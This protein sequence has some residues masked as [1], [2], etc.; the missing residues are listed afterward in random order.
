MATPTPVHDGE[1]PGGQPPAAAALRLSGGRMLLLAVSGVLFVVALI[2][3][4]AAAWGIFSGVRE[5]HLLSIYSDIVLPPYLV[6]C[7]LTALDRVPR[8]RLKSWGT[9]A[10]LLV[11]PALL[12]GTIYLVVPAGL[13]YALAH[14][15][16][17]P[18][19]VRADQPADDKASSSLID[20]VGVAIAWSI[21]VG[22]L[23]M[24]LVYLSPLLLGR[25]RYMQHP[26]HAMGFGLAGFCL[27][28][29][30]ALV[31]QVRRVLRLSA[32]EQI[33]HIVLVVALALVPVRIAV[34]PVGG[35][36]VEAWR[37]LATSREDRMRHAPPLTAAEQTRREGAYFDLSVAVQQS[38]DGRMG[39][40]IVIGDLEATGL[41]RHVGG[42][43][44]TP[45]PDLIATVTG[46]YFQPETGVSFSLAPTAD[47]TSTMSIDVHYE[48]GR[49]TVSSADRESY[50]DRLAL[51]T[52]RAVED[53]LDR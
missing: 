3:V 47:T 52:I 33:V 30:V 41:F 49:S 13:W 35:F 43:S 8:N 20:I 26:I 36:M 22:F 1:G 16:S 19:T 31:F 32:T 14:S 2:E 12:S 11:V 18:R 4:V 25:T 10:H 27:A 29:F 5:I 38:H 34:R 15:W 44:E 23:T 53:V 7:I 24:V 28:L 50:L 37:L 51:E 42:A 21:G 45:E 48:R 46:R 40:A 17:V 9:V 39:S 6:F